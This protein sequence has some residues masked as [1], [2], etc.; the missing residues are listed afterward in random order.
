[1]L[2]TRLCLG[3]MA[4]GLSAHGAESPGRVALPVS[5]A[6]VL[7]A[8]PAGE[9]SRAA[10]TARLGPGAVVP[11]A[12]SQLAAAPDR[13]P[14]AEFRLPPS[15][16][17]P[18]PGTEASASRS[19]GRTERNLALATNTSSTFGRTPLSSR[20]VGRSGAAWAAERRTSAAAG[21]FPY[22]ACGLTPLGCGEWLIGGVPGCAELHP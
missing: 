19:R 20:D 18:Q 7:P 17:K 14:G 4:V 5:T 3:R 12:R 8:T 6:S 2:H 1:M 21:L 10:G 11:P 15:D 9:P 13:V 16:A 22:Q